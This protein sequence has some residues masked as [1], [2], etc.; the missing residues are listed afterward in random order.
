MT[1]IA[2]ESFWVEP[3]CVV[4]A[5]PELPTPFRGSGYVRGCWILGFWLTAW[6]ATRL[7]QNSRCWT[8]RT[9]VVAGRERPTYAV[10]VSLS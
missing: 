10:L 1:T 9:R 2:F 4:T 5:K 6:Q 7:F 8:D 3:F